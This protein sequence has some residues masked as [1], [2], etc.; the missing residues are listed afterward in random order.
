MH[1]CMHVLSDAYVTTYRSVQHFMPMSGLLAPPLVCLWPTKESKVPSWS[2]E[3]ESAPTGPSAMANSSS[4]SSMRFAKG[5]EIVRLPYD[6]LRLFLCACRH[7]TPI[8]EQHSRIIGG[9]AITRCR[10]LEIQ[11]RS[12]KGC[13]T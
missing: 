3:A 11:N 6:R 9:I 10:A 2:M 12:L 7:S 8:L 1:A 13:S 5:V 4:S